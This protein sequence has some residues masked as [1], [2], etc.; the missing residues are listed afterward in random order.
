V[1]S[2]YY[3]IGRDRGYASQP[4]KNVLHVRGTLEG[5]AKANKDYARRGQAAV[6]A[7][8]AIV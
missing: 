3:D 1:A 6:G 2:A 8:K 7:P 5:C 4:A